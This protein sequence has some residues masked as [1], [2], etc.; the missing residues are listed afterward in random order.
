[1][2]P[3]DSVI[4]AFGGKA[5]G[6][7]CSDSFFDMLNLGVSFAGRYVF[8]CSTFSQES[9][10]MW[11]FDAGSY[12]WDFINTTKWLDINITTNELVNAS[13]PENQVPAPREQ[14]TSAV[15]GNGLYVF[16]GKSR[17]FVGYDDDGVPKYDG[18][19]IYDKVYGDLWLFSWKPQTNHYIYWR[20]SRIAIS[21]TSTI[22][23]DYN[24]TEN[25]E[26][27]A[28]SDGQ[29]PRQGLCIDKLVVTV[30]VD[31]PCINQVELSLRGPG[32]T[33][34]S[35]DYFPSA[36]EWR[37][38]LY[39][40]SN[41]N[42]TGCA[43]GIHTLVFDDDA[44]LRTEEGAVSKFPFQSGLRYMPDGKLGE[45]IGTSMTSVWRLEMKDTDEDGISGHLVSFDLKF[46][47]SECFEKYTLTD[48][49][50]TVD[51][52]QVPA[53]SGAKSITHG[54]YIFFFGGYDTNGN[55]LNDLHRFHTTSQTWNTLTPSR[56]SSTPL[57][58]AMSVGSNYVLTAHGVIRFA[59]YFRLPE[60]TEA[61]TPLPLSQTGVLPCE[62]TALCETT[63]GGSYDN[64]VYVLDPS[65]LKWRLLT[66]FAQPLSIS[67][68]SAWN[69]GR[70]NPRYLSAAG[71]IPAHAIPWKTQYG[72]RILYDQLV[73]STKANHAGI[74][75]DSL[76][77]F[78]GFDGASGA[79]KDGSNGGYM[80]DMIVLRLGKL[81]TPGARY[82]TDK[83][84]TTKC[85]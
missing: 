53:R 76:I 9:N 66:T 51:N 32:V 34:F 48:L 42:G 15:V 74:V 54:D 8:Q 82:N 75:S 29:S 43:G 47:A 30:V 3:V 79:K 36:N 50:H 33:Y 20:Q 27:M 23:V 31:H 45:Y 21:E 73:D 2:S 60:L 65:T 14:H 59:G 85:K 35:A 57:E 44:P 28:L 37:V 58:T 10:E 49:S 84:R 69:A 77:V 70:P 41:S 56:F 7:S 1:M 25:A 38:P 11:R 13:L 83:M 4:Y 72:N 52:T 62:L 68:N 16:G 17:I 71:F 26:L 67:A 46:T 18:A 22:S 12:Q 64:S 40:Q 5:N 81:S 78:G 24:A 61:N 19:Y 39:T 55:V 6:Y 80:N 63:D